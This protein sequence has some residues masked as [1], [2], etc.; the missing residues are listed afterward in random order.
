MRKLEC[1]F[2]I[3]EEVAPA[4]V[5]GCLDE[6]Q[7]LQSLKPTYTPLKK[8]VKRLVFFEYRDKKHAD[9][10][11]GSVEEAARPA[12]R[13]SDRTAFRE[14]AKN[15]DIRCL[16]YLL[17]YSDSC[18]GIPL[19]SYIPEAVI[20]EPSSFPHYYVHSKATFPLTTLGQP[21]GVLG[22]Y[23]AQQEGAVNCCAQAAVKAV[24]KNLATMTGVDVDIPYTQ[25]NAHLCIDH[26]TRHAKNGCF[27][28]EIGELLRGVGMESAILDHA[29]GGESTADA[30]I[31]TAYYAVEC[32]LPAILCFGGKRVMHAMAVVGHTF[33]PRLWSAT[34]AAAYFP[35]DR[36]YMPSHSWMQDLLVQDDKVGPYCTL[37]RATLANR[38]PLVIIPRFPDSMMES[39]ESVEQSVSSLF[40]E[41]RFGNQTFFSKLNEFAEKKGAQS[42]WLDKLLEH[43][44]SGTFVLRTLR[45][46]ADAYCDF[47]KN[48]GMDVD[49]INEV[50]DR[51]AGRRTIWLVELSIPELFQINNCR[52]GEVLLAEDV[53]GAKK[54]PKEDLEL[55]AVRI[56]GVLTVVDSSGGISSY[57]IPAMQDYYPILLLKPNELTSHFDGI[58]PFSP[59]AAR[60]RD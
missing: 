51:L 3:Q 15:Q 60:L 16:G 54:S 12:R 21:F 22:S 34:A 17:L 48:N 33:D 38:K 26:K 23:F 30:I 56:P 32:G 46:T 57:P 10:F 20:V 40:S 55:C 28:E 9:L 36:T 24:L 52:L 59:A 25:M 44:S 45:T 53:V 6:L 50:K 42:Y 47:L 35:S 11:V 1:D 2:L 13:S 18:Q 29:A 49:M 27:P 7:V 5:Q 39:P 14:V 37:Q 43:V 31:D 8:N 19:S 58:H 41:R 4:S